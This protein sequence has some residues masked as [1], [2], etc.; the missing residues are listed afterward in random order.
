MTHDSLERG[1]YDTQIK[2]WIV[3]G[4]YDEAVHERISLIKREGF[5]S[6]IMDKLTSMDHADSFVKAIQKAHSRSP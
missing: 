4:H 5:F 1:D 6:S 3:E 2:E